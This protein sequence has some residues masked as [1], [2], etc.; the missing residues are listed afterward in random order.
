MLPDLRERFAAVQVVEVSAGDEASLIAC[1]LT[2]ETHCVKPDDACFLRACRAFLS[3]KSHEAWLAETVEL[4]GAQRD[5]LPALLQQGRDRGLLISAGRLLEELSA[6]A[7][8]Y[9]PP[10]PISAVAIPTCDRPVELRRALSSY[11]RN[12]QRFGRTCEFAVMDDTKTPEGREANR[13]LLC[14]LARREGAVIRYAGIKEKRCFAAALSTESG[15]AKEVVDV[16]LFGMEGFNNTCGANRNA[17]LLHTVGDLLLSV[18]DDTVCQIVAPPVLRQEVALDSRG[19]AAWDHWFYASREEVLRDLSTRDQDV[20]SIHE[21]ALG[22][23][24]DACL[25]EHGGRADWQRMSASLLGH[26]AVHADGKVLLTMNGLFGNAGYGAPLLSYGAPSFERLVASEQ[27]YHAALSSMEMIRSVPATT[28]TM[29]APVAGGFLGLD[30]RDFLPPFMPVARGEDSIFGALLSRCFPGCM[31]A[32]LPW[33]L[34]HS[35][36]HARIHDRDAILLDAKVP[37]MCILVLSVL[38]HLPASRASCGSARLRAM[39]AAL[40]EYGSL[41]LRDFC[42]EL[43]IAVLRSWGPILEQYDR[44]LSERDRRPAYWAADVERLVQAVRAHVIQ[45]EYIVP[46]E[47]RAGRSAADALCLL[48]GTFVTL[49]RL[50]DTWPALLDAARALRARGERLAGEVTIP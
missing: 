42:S 1:R 8:P 7:G 39:G 33:L 3:L 14:D 25:A 4:S 16:A 13:A 50:L 43:R 34:L 31:Q 23:R 36:P 15:V 29:D 27:A 12:T 48:K 47:L 49:G 19:I 40:I 6:A 37:R 38:G 10:P 22:K 44:M 5:A 11:M 17:V 21:E 41:P 26:T 45:P 30:N 24:L 9:S 46:S 32:L 18:D 28:L 2:G 20:L 35:P